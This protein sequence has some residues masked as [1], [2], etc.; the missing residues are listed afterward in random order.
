[1]KRVKFIQAVKG[2]SKGACVYLQDEEAHRAIK[3]GDA[4]AIDNI[5]VVDDA[6]KAGLSTTRV[7]FVRTVP[8]YPAACKATL[9]SKE[10]KKH[11]ASGAAKE[12]P[13]LVVV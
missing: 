2:F 12:F 3:Q 9:L 1:M 13:V 11:I 5:P 8:G 4:V 10:A 6:P 7:E